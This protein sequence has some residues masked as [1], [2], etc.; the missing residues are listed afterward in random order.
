M[1]ENQPVNINLGVN[2]IPQNNVQ[3]TYSAVTAPQGNITP[4]TEPVINNQINGVNQQNNI[5]QPYTVSFEPQPVQPQPVNANVNTVV[6]V[7]DTGLD[8]VKLSENPAVN[9]YS[10]PQFTATPGNTIVESAPQVSAPQVGPVVNAQPQQIPQEQIPVG[11]IQPQP[12]VQEV[13]QQPQVSDK[14]IINTSYLNKVLSL[15]GKAASCKPIVPITTIIQ[16]IMSE[17]G[18]VIKATNGESVVTYNDTKLR[19]TQTF[20]AAV[21]ADLLLKL[22]SRLKSE[23]VEFK[24]DVVNNVVYLYSGENSF[25]LKDK[26]DDMTGNQINIVDEYANLNGEVRHI[27][28]KDFKQSVSNVFTFTS[29]DSV[30]PE[31]ANVYMADYMYGTDTNIAR[32]VNNIPELLNDVIC[33]DRKL[34][35]LIKDIDFDGDVTL[36]LNKDSAGNVSSLVFTDGVLTLSGITAPNAAQYPILTIKGF[37]DL[38]SPN[39]VIINKDALLNALDIVSLFVNADLDDNEFV[40]TLDPNSK[41]LTVSSQDGASKQPIRIDGENIPN[42]KF[43]VNTSSLKI[44]AESYKGDNIIMKVDNV[45]VA[46][47][48]LV[49][50]DEVMFVSLSNK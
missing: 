2:N 1:E 28:Y 6:N 11:N 18:L 43:K 25:I 9:N 26:I 8:T 41:I 29:D 7:Q 20:S 27:N 49:T 12:V 5:S 19:F 24:P 46:Y 13:P 39:T 4:V 30:M 35:A 21:P 34:A 38:D 37:I 48:K 22:V 50:E 42:V 32:R 10:A 3:N 33:I 31:S 17:D 16:V 15:V 23:T 36:K 40:V 44:A 47:I 14:Y 45:N